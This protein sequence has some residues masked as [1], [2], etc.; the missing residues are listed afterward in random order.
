MPDTTVIKVD[1][2]YSPKGPE[3]QKYLA[4]GRS[5]S[6]RLWEREAPGESKTPVRRD[7]ETVG[8]V[9]SG[10]AELLIE[11]QA[12]LLHPGTSWVVP[13]GSEHSYRILEEFTAVEATTPP[14][15]VHSRDEPAGD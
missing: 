6:M 2:A 14:A 5:L 13:K 7:Y 9:I 4:N 10:Q 1:G 8:Y 3:G 12:V 11:G 15:E